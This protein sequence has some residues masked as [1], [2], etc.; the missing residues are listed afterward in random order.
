MPFKRQDKTKKG[1]SLRGLID[2]I[3]L[4]LI[5]S[6]VTLSVSEARVDTEETGEDTYHLDLPKTHTRKTEDAG[7]VVRTLM[8]QLEYA[9]SSDRESQKILYVLRPSDRNVLSIAEAKTNA[10]RDSLFAPF[11]QDFLNLTERAFAET[12]PCRLIREQVRLYKA[13]HFFE[14]KPTNT[15]EIR[16]IKDAEFRIINFILETCSAYGD[17]I[18][19]INIRTIAGIRGDDG[20]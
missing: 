4:L 7:E 6:L 5:F 16:A 1:L 2:I 20:V 18:P 10:L 9:D 13:D 11:P 17:T 14:A 3:F 15:I 19:R 12:R 8:F